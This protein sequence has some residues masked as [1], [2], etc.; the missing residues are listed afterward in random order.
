MQHLLLLLPLLP[1]V[2]DDPGLG[3]WLQGLLLLLRRKRRGH[4][5][6]LLRGE[7]PEKSLGT[8]SLSALVKPKLLDQQAKPLGS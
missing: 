4:P 2:Y 1:A 3:L 6:T 7:R 8:L 5:G